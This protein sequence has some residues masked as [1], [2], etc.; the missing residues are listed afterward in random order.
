MFLKQERC[1]QVLNQTL[2]LHHVGT[3]ALVCLFHP[4]SS[5]EAST[6]P[7]IPGDSPSAQQVPTNRRRHVIKGTTA[8]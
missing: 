7:R 8:G 6:V 3:T 2:S 5:E 1:F 4:W